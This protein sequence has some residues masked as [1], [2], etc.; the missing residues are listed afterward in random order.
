MSK[1]DDLFDL[2]KIMSKSEKRYFKVI[3]SQH[4]VKE[5]NKYVLLFD[6]VNKQKEYDEKAVKASITDEMLKKNFAVEKNYLYNFLLKTL[7]SFHGQKSLNAKASNSLYTIRLL[8]SKALYNQSSKLIEKT[9]KFA[10]QSENF[11][12]LLELLK[13]KIDFLEEVAESQKIKEA[14]KRMFEVQNIQNNIIQYRYYHHLMYE[15]LSKMGRVS[16]KEIIEEAQELLEDKLLKS[17]DAG[18]CNE[19]KIRFHEIW[20]LYYYLGKD[21][22]KAYKQSELSFEIIDNVPLFKTEKQNNYISC[23]NNYIIFASS[24]RKFDKAIEKT[25]TLKSLLT[26]DG[27]NRGNINIFSST[28]LIETNYFVNTSQFTKVYDIVDELEEGLELFGG[29]MFLSRKYGLF[30]N[31]AILY[32]INGDFNLALKWVNRIIHFEEPKTRTDMMGFAWLLNLIIHFELKNYDYLDYLMKS[33][34]RYLNNKNQ[35]KETVRA[36]IDV[37]KVQIKQSDKDKRHQAYLACFETLSASECQ[38]EIGGSGSEYFEIV[39]WIRSKVEKRSYANLI[40]EYN[41]SLG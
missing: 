12:L 35:L 19:A 22:K 21:F 16:R 24:I 10:E 17:V 25:S 34:Q 13:L 27:T 23:L 41:N 31:V 11:T 7:T 26:K 5:K 38:K 1:R 14:Y 33:T 6:A 9:I 8:T 29:K 39:L 18:L 40:E 28:A 15:L 2:I 30:F 20:G 32:F 3:A 4:T 37:M 36:L